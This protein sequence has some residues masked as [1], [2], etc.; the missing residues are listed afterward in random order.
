MMANSG[1]LQ[2][3]FSNTVLSGLA[4]TRGVPVGSCGAE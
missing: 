1:Y 4:F 2:P 3:T